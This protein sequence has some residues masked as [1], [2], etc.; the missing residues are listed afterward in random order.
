M[1]EAKQPRTKNLPP[2]RVTEAEER[3]VKRAARHRGRT[4]SDLVRDALKR[5]LERGEA[6]QCQ[7]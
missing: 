2:V 6:A 5:Y 1:F 3:A 4:V 7:R